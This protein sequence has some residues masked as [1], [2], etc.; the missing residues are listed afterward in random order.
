MVGSHAVEQLERALGRMIDT[1]TPK[2]PRCRTH[3][4]GQLVEQAG[5]ATA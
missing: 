4:E 1:L 2:R 3:F 5:L